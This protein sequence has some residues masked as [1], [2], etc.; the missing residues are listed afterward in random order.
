MVLAG[1]LTAEQSLPSIRAMAREQRVSVITVQRAYEHL[2][3]EGLIHSR[4]G[5]GFFISQLSD[6]AKSNMAKERLALQLATH[7]RVALAEGLD[8]TAV[9]YILEDVLKTG[10]T[11]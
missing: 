4:R 1:D 7:I 2:E 6:E 11:E 10:N 5:K 8:A 9:R 3:R